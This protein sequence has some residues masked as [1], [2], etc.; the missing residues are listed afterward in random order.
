MLRASVYLRS[1]SSTIILSPGTMD[2]PSDPP[3]A[4]P[5]I[6]L[7]QAPPTIDL[8]L[9]PIAPEPPMPPELI[10]PDEFLRMVPASSVPISELLKAQI[11][12]AM[13]TAQ[14][15]TKTSTSAKSCIVTTDLNYEIRDVFTAD[16]PPETWIK[17]AEELV[18]LRLTRSSVRSRTAN[19]ERTHV[20]HPTDRHL[21]FPPWIVRA[22]KALLEIV[23]IR[24]DWRG[25][26]MWVD[27]QG[28]SDLTNTARALI[29]QTSWGST[30]AELTFRTDNV[31]VSALC[32]FAS[33][34]WVSDGNI[35]VIVTLLNTLAEP[36]NVWISDA[37]LPGRLR[38]RYRAEGD[39][40]FTRNG[41][42]RS[43]AER[44]VTGGFKLAL[45]PTNLGDKSHWIVFQVDLTNKTL[46]WGAWHIRAVPLP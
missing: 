7:T 45:I 13:L 18:R 35:K 28:E 40:A 21:I 42:L 43:A 34:R 20:A 23:K 29:A 44:L 19:N 30:I 24:D 3:A 5:I 27:A 6:D 16:V 36:Q 12:R 33:R 25:T 11:P 37:V 32:R 2:N 10:V 1:R 14:L 8:T 9:A 38:G 15:T 41:D 26:M 46:S 4:P 39:D 31:F 22:W 17:A